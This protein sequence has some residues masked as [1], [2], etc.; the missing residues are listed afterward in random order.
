MAF[1]PDILLPRQTYPILENEDIKENALVRETTVN[2]YQFLTKTGYNPDDILPLAI[3][4]QPSLREVFELSIFLYGYYD[5]RHIGIRVDDTSLYADWEKN[6][7][8]LRAEDIRFTQ[9]TAYPLFFSASKLDRQEIDYNGE[10]HT[11]S[12]SHRPTRVNYWHFELWVKDSAENRI[13][14]DRSNAHTKYLAKSVLE[15]IIA[16]A[17]ISKTSVNIFRRSDFE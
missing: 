10:T 7:M 1:Y 9:K 4:P 8:E 14:R 11:L 13:P 16:E 2:V 12:F 17:V 5:E 15:Y 3:A 6:Q